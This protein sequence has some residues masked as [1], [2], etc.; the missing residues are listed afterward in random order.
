MIEVDGSKST[1]EINRLD[2]VCLGP[3]RTASSWLQEILSYHPEICL[4]LG[5]KETMFFDLRFENGLDWY[6][7]HF[8]KRRENQFCGEI[9]P[10]YFDSE[11]ARARLADIAPALKIIVL[12]RNPIDRTFSLYRHHL[13]KGRIRSNFTDALNEFPRL[14]SSSKYSIHAEAWENQFADRQILYL[15]QDE[16]RTQPEQV[17]NQV[18]DFLD[19]NRIA[20][21][22]VGNAV[23]NHASAP[24]FR[25][26][27]WLLS[28]TAT[29]LRS[30]RLYWIVN[31]AKSIGLKQAFS[32]GE[33]LEPMSAT[34]KQRLLVE[35]EP[36]IS[37]IERRF[38]RDLSHWR[39]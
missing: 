28:S 15:W 22:S 29:A 4:P 33:P 3:Q 38:D 24:R 5:V 25:S 35:F 20:L 12:L 2:F 16:V 30:A 34:A 10:T 19:V 7:W 26:L 1:S 18:C 8:R 11:L 37:W 17:L 31:F 9:A 6:F 23:I 32:G 14:I 36:D 13:S 27:A 21:P 39:M